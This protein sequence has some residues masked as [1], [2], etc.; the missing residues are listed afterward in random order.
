VKIIVHHMG[1]MIPFFEGR[2][3][4]GFEEFTQFSK[5][6]ELKAAR[7]GL[8]KPPADYYRMFYAD[9]ALFGAAAGTRCGLDYFGAERCLFG[10]DAPFGRGAGTIEDTIN[11]IDGLEIPENDRAAIYSGNAERLLRL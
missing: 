4:V 10:T 7:A 6:E 1:A 5:D 2:I 11:I 9:T 3:G 8:T